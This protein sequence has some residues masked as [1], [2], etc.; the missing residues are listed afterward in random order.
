MSSIHFSLFFGSFERFNKITFL[1]FIIIER[2]NNFVILA[3]SHVKDF[4]YG[5]WSVVITLCRRLAD[6][7]MKNEWIPTL[8]KLQSLNGILVNILSRWE[9][10]HLRVDINQPIHPFVFRLKVKHQS[11]RSPNSSTR[12]A[13]GTTVIS[14]PI[15]SQLNKF[16]FSIQQAGS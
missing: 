11:N 7:M 2:V 8:K 3:R 13:L 14:S 9:P 15:F 10:I 16:L 1:S 5:H 6:D 4:K 12:H